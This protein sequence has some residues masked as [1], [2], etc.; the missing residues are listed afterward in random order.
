VLALNFG[1]STG[2]LL[3]RIAN[4]RTG[5]FI[6]LDETELSAGLGISAITRDPQEV[7]RRAAK[8]AVERIARPDAPPRTVSLPAA[9]VRRGSGEVAP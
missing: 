5:A 2:V 7:G 9:L 3:D 1:I 4:R 6:A 8:L